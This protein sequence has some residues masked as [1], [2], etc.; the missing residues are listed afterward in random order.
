MLLR[1]S[2][3][4]FFSQSGVGRVG[5]RAAQEIQTGGSN[6]PTW[7]IWFDTRTTSSSPDVRKSPR[8]DKGPQ[9]GYAG[10]VA[11]EAQPPVARLG[12]VLPACSGQAD[13]QNGG[14]RG[15]EGVVVMGKTTT[16]AE[17]HR[18]GFE[19]LLQSTTGLQMA[20]R[21]ETGPR[22]R[23]AGAVSPELRSDLTA[24]KNQS[25]SQSLR[26]AMGTLLRATRPA[27]CGASPAE[28]SGDA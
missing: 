6:F 5:G 20:V 15:L 27:S 26:S 8:P 13:L 22:I 25:R 3:R 28:T 14:Q 10:R 17:R 7:S 11:G 1:F 21:R 9:A 19:A 18:L 16:P 23:L 24:R 4:V 12:A 2:Q